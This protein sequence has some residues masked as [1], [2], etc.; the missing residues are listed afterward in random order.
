MLTQ[1]IHTPTEV[2]GDTTVTTFVVVVSAVNITVDTDGVVD[3]EGLGYGPGVGPGAGIQ[4]PTHLIL[5]GS[6]G[7][8][9]GLGGKGSSVSLAGL[10]YDNVLYPTEYGS[11]GNT[12]NYY[13]SDLNRKVCGAI[14][15]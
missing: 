4:D 13:N 7:S 9:G 10:A 11:G 8:H 6:G 2:L 3:A 5:A 15:Y 12:N 1:I 14:M